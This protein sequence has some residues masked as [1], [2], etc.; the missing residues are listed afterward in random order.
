MVMSRAF[1]WRRLIDQVG[2]AFAVFIVVSPAILVFLW[3]LS[4]SLKS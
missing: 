3:M 4:L 2:L 1:N